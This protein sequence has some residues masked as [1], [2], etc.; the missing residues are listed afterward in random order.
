MRIFLTGGSGFVG[1]AGAVAVLA[2][3]AW[4]ILPL[5]GAPPLQRT[6]VLLIGPNRATRAFASCESKQLLSETGGRAGDASLRLG[7]L[8]QMRW[9]RRPLRME[10]EMGV[11]RV[12]ER[13]LRG[14]VLPLQDG[15]G[16]RVVLGAHPLQKLA[17]IGLQ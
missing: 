10:L 17:V 4:R 13:A 6:T 1:R 2:E 15:A 11:R 9:Q 12:H 3:T 8:R 16:G 5:K 14:H 7:V